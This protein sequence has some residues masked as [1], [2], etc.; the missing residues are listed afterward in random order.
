ML[1]MT[2]QWLELLNDYNMILMIENGIRGG[3]SQCSNR[4]AVANN[5]YMKENYDK[6]KEST[7]LEYLDANNLYGWAMSKYLPYGGFKWGGTNIDVL[8]IPDDSPKGYILEV[9]LS[10]PKNY[11]TYI[12]IYHWLQKTGLKTRD[13]PNCSLPYMIRKS[14]SSTTPLLSCI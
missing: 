11:M 4:Y 6:T 3:I 2:K 1:K 9:D 7:F 14:T 10:Y 5:K 13:F 12:Q 8:K